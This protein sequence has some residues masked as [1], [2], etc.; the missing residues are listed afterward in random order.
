MI[1]FL[2][3]LYLALTL[4]FTIIVTTAGISEIV[5]K[6]FSETVRNNNYWLVNLIVSFLWSIWY[7]YYLN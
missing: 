2:W 3:M 4:L 5:N 7:F 1:T 6:T